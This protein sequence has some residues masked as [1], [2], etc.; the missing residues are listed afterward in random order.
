VLR[1]KINADTRRG[2]GK[3]CLVADREHGPANNGN[4]SN[5]SD[6]YNEEQEEYV[7]EGKIGI[8]WTNEAMNSL[9]GCQECSR[10]CDGCYARLR[11]YRFAKCGITNRDNRYSD[12]VEMVRKPALRDGVE[13]EKQQLRFTGRILFNPAK[14]YQFLRNN[15]PGNLVFVDEFSDLLHKAV[16][17]DVILE[18]FRVFR[19]VPWLQFQVLTKRAN[20]LKEL[21]AAVIEEF[22]EWPQNVWMGVSVCTRAKGE[23]NKI[24]ALGKTQARIKWVSFEPWLSDPEMAL[25]EACPDLAGLL[26]ES[27]I[28]WNVI[29][30]ESGSKK[31][32]RLMTLEDAQYLFSSSKHAGCS[33]HFK[34]L[35]AKLAINLGVYGIGDHRSKGGNLEQIPPNLRERDWPENMTWDVPKYDLSF[36]PRFDPKKLIKFG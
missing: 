24:A 19:A 5:T 27:G 17:M 7:A 14:M 18:H 10:G 28:A 25:E 34:Q 2:A 33:L 21:N 9:V 6:V 36:E 4:V 1:L 22:G 20:R 3:H 30:G 13:V 35:G 12:L 26:G 29:G 15:A 31:E 11:V 16:P 8:S 32:S 23:L